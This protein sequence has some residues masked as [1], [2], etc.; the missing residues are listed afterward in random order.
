MRADK[1]IISSFALLLLG[2][3]CVATKTKKKSKSSRESSEGDRD[4]I[5]RD[6]ASVPP[7]SAITCPTNISGEDEYC[8]IF[9]Q[10]GGGG[11]R[12]IDILWVVDNSGSMGDEQ[13]NLAQNFQT[14]INQFASQNQ[15]V[16]FNMGIITTDSS[17]NRLRIGNASAG[18]RPGYNPWPAFIS[19][20]KAA[21]KVGI[22]GNGFECGLAFSLKFLKESSSWVRNNAHLLAIYV[23]DENDRSNL[24][25]SSTLC[26]YNGETAENESESNNMADAYFKA[27]SALKPASLFKAF[28]IVDTATTDRLYLGQ[29]YIRLTELSNGKSYSI[30]NDFSTILQDF[31]GIVAKIASQFQLKYPAQEGTVEVFIDGVPAPQGD[32]NY[33][34]G[35]R[36]IRFV[37]DFFANKQGK[38]TIKVTYRTK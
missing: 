28:A 27:I 35:Q 10:E 30:K 18:A 16:D 6:I 9:T 17:T 3:G 15:N 12:P 26:N 13:Q 23:S 22:S 8:Q 25:S 29:R 38:S 20:F 2:C 24:P 36:A 21:I 1:I 4:N 11:N 5:S 32:W 37:D 31:G 14:F 33:L 7:A 34:A 19:D